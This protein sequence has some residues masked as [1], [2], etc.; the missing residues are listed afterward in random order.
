MTALLELSRLAR[1]FTTGLAGRGPF[2][3]ALDGVDLQVQAGE[4]H[5]VIGESGCGKTTMARLILNLDRPTAGKA[6]FDD[7]DI[8]ALSAKRLRWFRRD[9]Q[10]VFQ[11]PWASL[12]PRMRVRDTVAEALIATTSLSRKEIDARVARALEEV[13]LRPD[14]MRNFPHEFSGGQRQ[15]IAIASALISNPRLIILDEPVSALDVSIRAQIMNLLKDLQRDRGMA[16]L[17]IAHDLAT[18]RFLADQVSVMYLGRIVETGPAEEVFATPRHP[19]TRALISAALPSD[20]DT[21]SA[22][23]ILKGESPSPLS[24]PQGCPFHPRCPCFIGSICETDRPELQ[25]S[26]RSQVSCHL[27]SR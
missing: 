8:H 27:H 9:V 6:C 1:H 14:Q 2:V 19:Y 22:E 11:D 7:Q 25:S 21:D 13:E 20:P 4:T 18:T 10:A 15:R 3:R 12:N 16:F 23:I 26:G 17:L 24:V 5:A